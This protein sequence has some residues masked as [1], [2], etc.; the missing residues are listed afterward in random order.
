M[1]LFGIEVSI[2]W[3][4][5]ITVAFFMTRNLSSF[6]LSNFIFD[7]LIMLTLG[8]LIVGHELAHALTARHFGYQTK[9]IVLNLFGGVAF[10]DIAY[11]K[12]REE[13][14]VA[15]AGPLFNLILGIP[16]LLFCLI[17]PLQIIVA[18]QGEEAAVTTFGLYLFSFAVINTLMAV[19]NLLP[20]YP[21]DGGR[22][23][24]S[25][26]S[27]FDKRMVLNISNGLTL[28]FAALFVIWG[29]YVVNPFLILLAG[30]MALL[31]WAER[32]KMYSI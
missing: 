18:G 6:D 14:W 9:K 2:H 31:V 28:F 22:I 27:K 4:Y 16:T 1:K 8:G 3:T 5:W 10:M 21:M 24:R 23:L 19:F 11:M 12:P 17:N 7:A 13:F 29:I 30:V 20:A 32:K 25:L 15:F 26:L